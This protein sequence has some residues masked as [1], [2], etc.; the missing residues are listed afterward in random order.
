M[1]LPRFLTTVIAATRSPRA[2]RSEWTLHWLL[3]ATIVLP[4]VIFGAAA[5]ISY[6]QNQIDARDRL[7]RNLGTVYEHALKVFETVELTSRYLDEVLNDADD[8]D[9]RAD[10]GAFHRRLKSLTD[11]CRS[12]PTSGSSTPTAA[13]WCPAPCFRFRAAQLVRSRYF[14]VHPNNAVQDLYIGDVVGA[15][16]QRPGSS[17]LLHAQPQARRRTASSAASRRSRSRRTIS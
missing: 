15:R 7:Q 17:A 10:E 9:I 4:L 11:T 2:G 16:H 1:Q 8:P 12:S 13:R 5:T 3:A 6:R 14:R